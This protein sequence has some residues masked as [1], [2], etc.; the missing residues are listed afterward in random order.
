MGIDF[1][2]SSIFNE[3]TDKGQF[4]RLLRLAQKHH[5]QWKFDNRPIQT[6]AVTA[7]KFSSQ[8]DSI[9]FVKSNKI[10]NVLN[11]LKS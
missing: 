1:G 11:A 4:E 3:K 2:T 7:I 9:L 8:T 5:F 10:E 6:F